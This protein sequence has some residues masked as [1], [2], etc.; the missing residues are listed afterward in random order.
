MLEPLVLEPLRIVMRLELVPTRRPRRTVAAAIVGTRAWSTGPAIIAAAVEMVA[1][2]APAL[3]PI[4]C[5]RSPAI[6][7]IV[8]AVV[9]A[10]PPVHH[11]TAVAVD[12]DV[13]HVERAEGG[14][15]GC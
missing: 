9:V 3:P 1:L 15:E 14:I 5:V 11:V 2:A 10:P 6:V 4:S 8:T 7:V 12:C 13:R